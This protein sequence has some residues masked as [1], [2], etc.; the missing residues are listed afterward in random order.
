M[1]AF[2]LTVFTLLQHRYSLHAR[3]MSVQH[4]GLPQ[5]RTV[6]ILLASPVCAKLNWAFRSLTGDLPLANG[7]KTTVRDAIRD[8]SSQNRRE[9]KSEWT[10][11][12]CKYTP[13]LPARP[14]S[15]QARTACHPANIYNHETGLTPPPHGSEPIVMEST[16]VSL[17][18]RFSACLAHPSESSSQTRVKLDQLTSQ[19]SR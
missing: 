7:E 1:G 17:D 5:D 2:I 11:F 3:K 12:V 19:S 8:I 15:I 4:S 6:L 13:S 10:A 14:F 9:L 16:A 18:P